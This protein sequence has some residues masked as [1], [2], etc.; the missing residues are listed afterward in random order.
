MSNAIYYQTTALYDDTGKLGENFNEEEIALMF[1]T[2]SKSTDY[3]KTFWGDW[4]KARDLCLLSALRY[5]MLRP[6][7]AC[8]IKFRDLN[9]RTNQLHVRG[10]NNKEKKDRFVSIPAKFLEYY[11][12]YMQ[13]PKWMWKDSPFLFPSAENQFI[14]PQRWKMIFREKVLKASGLY[15]PPD[16]GKMPRT[17]SYLLRASGATELLDKGADPWTVAQTLGHSDLRTVKN[18]FFQTQKFRD[19]QKLFLNK[20][21][22]I[23]GVFVIPFIVHYLDVIDVI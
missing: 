14:H 23:A 3:L 5:M 4:M 12:W 15:E 7:E 13:F 9:F 10:E 18:Y 19:R 22:V 6:R 8:K 16:K 20:L 11:K 21:T 17:R 1:Y 2:L